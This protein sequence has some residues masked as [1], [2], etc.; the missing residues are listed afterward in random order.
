MNI[1]VGLVIVTMVTHKC[2]L[3]NTCEQGLA[4]FKTVM[5]T[6]KKKAG[7]SCQDWGIPAKE[8]CNLI[9]TFFTCGAKF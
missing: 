6:V 5:N 1:N 4:F 2:N 3:F 8:Y 7:I 9:K